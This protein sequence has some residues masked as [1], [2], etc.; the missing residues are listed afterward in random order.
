METGVVRGQ[1]L[2][3]K[4]VWRREACRKTEHTD[5]PSEKK[6]RKGGVVEMVDGIEEVG[7]CSVDV[8]VPSSTALLKI[9]G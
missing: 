1:D 3:S 2:C 9:D 7:N 5:N 4:D 6:R 8:C